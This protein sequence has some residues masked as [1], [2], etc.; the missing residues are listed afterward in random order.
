MSEADLH[1]DLYLYLQN[2]IDGE[3]DTQDIQFG[4]VRAEVNVNGGLADLVVYDRNDRPVLV[5]EAKRENGS[6][7][8]RDI[9]PY[10]PKVI[11]QAFDYAGRLGADYFATYN[12]TNCV[13]FDTFESG[14]H[15]L[16]RKTSAYEISEPSDFAPALLGEIDR[17]K[18]GEKKWDT[19]HQAFINRLQVYHQRLSSSFEEQA[20]EKVEEDEDF[21]SDL[22][23]WAEEQ[24]W[25]DDLSEEIF[26]TYAMQAAYLL[27]NK[28]VF[29]KL[30][31]DTDAYDVPIISMR[32]LIKPNH[33]RRV[34]D[35]LVDQLDFEAVYEHDEIFDV[36]ELR[37]RMRVETKELLDQLE[38]F[39]LSRFD[40]DIIGQIYQEIIPAEERHDLGQ[41]YTP[42][43]VVE[44]ICRLTIQSE[45]DMVL[46]PGCGS[47]GFLVGAYKRLSGLK[48]EPDHQELLDQLKGFDINRFPAHLS[49]INLALQNLEEKTRNVGVEVEDFFL[50]DPNQV[51]M[52][53]GSRAGVGGDEEAGTHEIEAF[54]AV[55]GNPP[56]IRQEQIADK[57]RC[58]RHLDSVGADLD[59]RSDIYSYFFTHATRFLE[60]GGRLGYITS[61]RWLSV[62]YGEALQDFLLEKFK[63]KAIVNFCKQQF[64]IPLISTCVVILERCTDG[65]ERDNNVVQ[66]L[67]LKEASD[68]DD[69]VVT[70]QKDRDPNQIIEEDTHRL[71]T[72][73]QEDLKHEDKWGR[74][75]WAPSAYWSVMK[76]APLVSLSELSRVAYGI[77]TG[78]N[79]FFYFRE[80]QEWEDWGIDPE[81]IT[82]LLKHHA[83]MDGTSLREE[84]LSWSVLDVNPF[85]EK[86]LNLTDGEEEAKR[87]LKKAGHNNLV[88]YIEWG[89]TGGDD[90]RFHER[91]SC[92]GRRIW[93]NLGKLDVPTLMVGKEYWRECVAP[94]NEANAVIDNRLYGVWS[95][96]DVE[97]GV[98]GGVLNSSIYPLMR[99]LHG[100][101]EQGQG[102]NRNTLMV[103]E[104]K[105]LPV[106]DPRQMEESDKQTIQEAFEKLMDAE[107]DERKD[108]EQAKDDLDRAV[109]SAIG[110]ED[111]TEDV[112]EAVELLLKAREK[113]A[114]QMTSVL[115]ESGEDM[116]DTLEGARR[117]EGDRGQMKLSL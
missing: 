2:A 95:N 81:F 103:Y 79:A 66:M 37:D 72:L 19:R 53:F 74:F 1:F 9:D 87:A 36:L 38:E 62:K 76:E 41:Y 16:D 63:I 84:E 58:R 98:L 22:M 7:Y 117:I 75:L 97:D 5:I 10:S 30:L 6:G 99:E 78:A 15:L 33:R 31:E 105:R 34:F 43:E 59:K 32:D 24:G 71:V 56:Y 57:E 101:T 90:R 49:A 27:M 64:K 13:L 83:E 100:R 4:D 102:M 45:D 52:A 109:M 80:D 3:I 39:N 61:D 116:A 40:H 55:V 51:R 18:V 23:Q 65:T 11:R 68:I 82:P 85:I 114:G 77:K 91:S 20:K 115:V 25:E 112:Q 42:A 73:Q 104:A 111:R 46:D 92:E 21:T 69:L 88:K 106:P 50:V 113:G 26:R 60:E 107:R 93:F 70:L 29:Y 67:Q 110:M 28:I 54:D 48:E 14:Q 47:G 12:G 8:D 108:T 94:F 35:E 44:L 86:H 96:S 17:L 89:E